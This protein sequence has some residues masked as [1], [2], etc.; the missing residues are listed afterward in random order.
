LVAVGLAHFSSKSIRL[1]V[2]HNESDVVATT[3]TGGLKLRADADGLAFIC[4]VPNTPTG[5]AAKT[6]K[7]HKCGMS[8]GYVPKRVECLKVS[9][10]DV[11]LIR[12]A[13]LRDITICPRGAVREAFAVLL[14]DEE[15][16]LSLHDVCPNE[17]ASLGALG[18]SGAAWRNCRSA[19]GYRHDNGGDNRAGSKAPGKWIFFVTSVNGLH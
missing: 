19:L 18:R 9:G 11:H 13:D 1:L 5:L 6:L 7:K 4:P 16:S 17:L 8:V 10:E 3:K 2:E 12:E 15:K 14:D